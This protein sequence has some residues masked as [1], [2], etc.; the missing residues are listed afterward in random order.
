MLWKKGNAHVSIIV[1]APKPKG[2]KEDSVFDKE[3]KQL[4]AESGKAHR[5]KRNA[6]I[7]AMKNAIPG[8]G[9]KLNVVK[10]IIDLLARFTKSYKSNCMVR[11]CCFFVGQCFGNGRQLY[12]LHEEAY[13]HNCHR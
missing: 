5:E 2:R 10:T 13:R 12:P 9:P 8:A 11:N 3:K 4:A 7:E 1:A 6:S